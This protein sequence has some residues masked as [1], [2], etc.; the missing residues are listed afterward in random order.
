MRLDLGTRVKQSI[1]V[2]ILMSSP[3]VALASDFGCSAEWFDLFVI[4]ASLPTTAVFWAIL[5]NVDPDNRNHLVGIATL[6]VGCVGAMSFGLQCDYGKDPT[7]FALLM[8]LA[9]AQPFIYCQDTAPKN[10]DRMIVCK[11][12]TGPSRTLQRRTHSRVFKRSF[13]RGQATVCHNRT[14]LL[15]KRYPKS[16]GVHRTTS[17]LGT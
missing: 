2:V 13:E 17:L 6:L 10:Q 8:S 16:K 7:T 14:P 11:A 9:G 1:V 3:R 15:D 4:L 12:D 5:R